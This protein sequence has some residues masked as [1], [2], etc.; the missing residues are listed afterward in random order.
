[1]TPR[2]ADTPLRRIARSSA[3]F[4]GSSFAR[5]ALGFLLSL[6]I[7]RG[8][9]A[10]RFGQ[11]VLCTAWASLLTVVADLGFGVL[12]TR[13][14]ARASAPVEQLVGGALTA[15]LVLVVPLGA[16]VYAGAGWIATDAGSIAGLRAAALLGVVGAAYG[17]FSAILVSQPR[18][19]PI[20]LGVDTAWLAVQV[21]ASSLIVGPNWSGRSG[22]VVEFG[23]AVGPDG[24]LVAL[25]VLATA[26]Q[27]AQIATALVLWRRVFAE[28]ST[29]G[30]RREPL[31]S[32][33]R[34]ALPFAGA[35]IVANLDLRVAPL[36]LGALSTSSAVGLYSAASR[37][38][39]FAA[40][41]PQ[42]VFGGALPVLSREFEHD[43]Q[44]TSRVFHKLDLSLLGFG[45]LT[46]A[47]Y[48]VLAPLLLRLAYGPAFTAA[49]PALMWI[50]A[51][52]IPALSNS[53]RKIALY[54]AGGES[55]VV[56]WSAVGLIVQAAAAAMLIPM[57][58]ATGAA[59]G[60]FIGE[61]AIWLPLRRTSAGR[62]Q[63]YAGSGFTR[64]TDPARSA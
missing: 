17:C 35:G 11:W 39:R 25:I 26:V 47:G 27:L 23:G 60:V 7:G 50:G 13:D 12:L 31:A 46:A 14:G 58:G 33:L 29:A 38:G 4:L 61:A 48:I 5:A 56:R 45:A 16:L 3:A 42:A 62:H 51:G 43:R 22:G 54:A 8:L 10:E 53:S 57:L 44:A 36:M 15:R 28:R 30:Q 52:L 55:T 40:F 41:G 24:Q 19:L 59:V 2:V 32:L 6:V 20:V 37:F 9:G 21:A 63:S 1:M 18:W 34:R 64:T 49:A